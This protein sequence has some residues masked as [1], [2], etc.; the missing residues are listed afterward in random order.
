M[1]EKLINNFTLLTSF[2]FFG[3]MARSR[4]LKGKVSRAVD[5]FVSGIVLGLFGLLLMQ[6]T[7]SVNKLV[8]ADFR[9]IA[10]IVSVYLGG[11]VSGFWTTLIIAGYRLYFLHGISSASVLAAL[12]AVLTYVIA[13]S[14]LPRK[15]NHLSKW[16]MVVGLSLVSTMAIFYVTLQENVLRIVLP[17]SLVFGMA[18]LFTYYLLRYLR[19][20]DDL[21]DMMRE[22]AHRD[23][24]T[25]LYNS[26]AFQTFFESKVV[27]SR[28]ASEVFSL[29]VVDIDHF[30]RVNDTYGHVAGDA[31]LQQLAHVLR[32]TF[33]PEDHIAR[34]GG[35]EFVVIVDH[36]GR[37]RIKPA[38]ERLR[39]N[40]ERHVFAL[41][42]GGT[43]RITV[44]VGAAVFPDIDA[45]ELFEKADQALYAAKESGRN[46]VC[47][48]SA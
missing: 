29:L 46:R 39:R 7:F 24:L 33:G 45:H 12:N 30:K 38:A 35:E 40:V 48:I 19:R 6:F 28:A 43:L 25:G 1:F 5:Y 16:A 20:S 22:A 34:K 10:I 44:S 4:Y 26:R 37:D 47:L 32:D 11:A 27:T 3:N 14:L 23:F 9:Q 15:N 2:L 13:A 18:G 17:Y 21:L 36:C 41:P 8:I 42:G 31:V